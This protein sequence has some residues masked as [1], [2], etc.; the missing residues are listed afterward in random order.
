MIAC[1]TCLSFLSCRNKLVDDLTT[2]RAQSDNMHN[3]VPLELIHRFTDANVSP[4]GYVGE[5]HHRAQFE[6]VGMSSKQEAFGALEAQIRERAGA[7]LSADEATPSAAA[8]SGKR[9]RGS[10]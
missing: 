2:I 8:A 7:L 10:S 4:D 1:P 6:H 9:A 3:P 5:L